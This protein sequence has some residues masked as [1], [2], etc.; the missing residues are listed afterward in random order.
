MSRPIL[1]ADLGVKG[2]FVLGRDVGNGPEI[3][4]VYVWRGWERRNR[5]RETESTIRYEARH[6]ALRRPAKIASISANTTTKVSDGRRRA[7]ES[8]AKEQGS[9]ID[10][11]AQ[12]AAAIIDV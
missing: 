7:I 5:K 4:A 11:F 12:Q 1:A 2:A 3:V 8:S 10:T 9:D 6:F